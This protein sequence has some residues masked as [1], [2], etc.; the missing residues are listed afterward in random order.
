MRKHTI[1]LLAA[2]LV[3][4][5]ACTRVADESPTTEVPAAPA[6]YEFSLSASLDEEAPKSDYTSTGVF[7]WSEGDQ[8]S[9][10][11]HNGDDNKFF[12]LT[13]VTV[14]GNT[15]TFSGP[16]TVGYE[17]GSNLNA[18]WALFPAS[19]LH[20]Y[21]TANVGVDKARHIS[22]HIPSYTDFTAPGAH[23][24]ANLPLAA[25]SLSGSNYVFSTMCGGYKFTFSNIDVEKVTFSVYSPNRMLS[26]DIPAA[27][28]GG[29]NLYHSSSGSEDDKWLSF[30]ASVPASKTVSFYVPYRGWMHD[31]QPYFTLKDAETGYSLCV[32]AAKAAFSGD[33]STDSGIKLVAIP[34]ISAS[35]AP[36]V[37]PEPDFSAMNHLTFTE[38]TT[39]LVN[40]ERGFYKQ[41][42]DIKSASNPVTPARIS[43]ARA[44][45]YTLMYDGFYLTD[46]MSGDIS[47]SYLDMI[48]TS[49]QNF[50]NGGVKCILRFAYKD[51]HEEED[52]P[53]DAPKNVVLRHI[54]Q[55][56]PILSAYADVIFVVQAGFIGSWGEWYYTSNFDNVADRKEVVDALLAAVPNTRQVALRTPAF[57]MNLYNLRAGDVITDAT[58]HGTSAEARLA[59]HND[60]FGAS[61]NDSG[62]FGNATFDRLFW[63]EESRYTIMGGE[64]CS[65]SDYCLCANS[66]K[67]LEDYHWT[68]LNS[69]WYQGVT[70]RWKTDGCWNEM[71][72]RLGYRLVLEDVYYTKTPVVG[73]TF[74]V[75]LRINN[76]GYSAPQNPRTAELVFI[77]EDSTVSTF[78][79]GSDPRTWHSGTVLVQSSFTLPAAKGTL[80]LNLSDPLLSTDP[81]FSIALANDDVFNSVT[82][83]NKLL[84]LN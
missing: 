42:A 48:R 29:K 38:A 82:G 28:N 59:G 33:L 43:A 72:D 27:E 36:A 66:L 47:D 65:V 52:K 53:W 20:V 7:S 35:G 61:S 13:A 67:D 18:K 15:A 60:C 16:V 49:L 39:P 44:E 24:S 23:Y 55:L 19:D 12:T 21:N 73:G 41:D 11:F 2:G 51:G 25:N 57:K 58:A 76:K 31:F 6:T 74:D 30:T 3:T 50:R 80:Y 75:A 45:G 46:F 69:G 1:L 70:D 37:S 5:A 77:A 8:I 34:A 54:E 83:Y 68:Y 78:P 32:K 9:V 71:R 84:E 81:R 56:Q 22:F 17:E 26:G 63:Q 40:P 4:F 64:T 62:T 10:L 79:L 14:S